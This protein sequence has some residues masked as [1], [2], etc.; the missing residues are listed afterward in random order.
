MLAKVRVRFPLELRPEQ[1]QAFH[2]SQR[3]MPGAVKQPV[4]LRNVQ[5]ALAAQ[6]EC[7]VT[8]RLEGTGEHELHA[9]AERQQE[10]AG[11]GLTDAFSH[12]SALLHPAVKVRCA[13]GLYRDDCMSPAV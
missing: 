13:D 12:T 2:P 7:L 6:P 8:R 5:P 11:D 3:R 10:Q 9:D 1:R 4:D